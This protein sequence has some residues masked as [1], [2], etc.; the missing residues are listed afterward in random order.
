MNSC[1]PSD[2]PLTDGCVKY[3]S[4]LFTHNSY[5]E[6]LKNSKPFTPVRY[7]YL[8]RCYDWLILL[9]KNNVALYNI[10]K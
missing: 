3:R 1:E 5:R 6:Q 8:R 9:K 10:I 4:A 7:W 2:T